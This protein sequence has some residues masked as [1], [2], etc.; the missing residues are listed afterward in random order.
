MKS[1]A[2]PENR[3]LISVAA[4]VVISRGERILATKL[5][6]IVPLFDEV[7]VVE[8]GSRDRSEAIADEY[9]AHYL[10]APPSESASGIDL[11]RRRIIQSDWLVELDG[12]ECPPESTILL[13]R[14]RLTQ[15]DFG[16]NVVV[17]SRGADF[18]SPGIKALRYGSSSSNVNPLATVNHCLT[19]DVIILSYCKTK[20]EYEMTCQCLRTLRASSDRIRFNVVMVETAAPHLLDGYAGAGKCF[21]DE[22]EVVFPQQKFNYNQFLQKGFERLQKSQARYLLIANNDVLFRPQFAEGLLESLGTYDSAS[23]WCPNYHEQYF[24]PRQRFHEGRRTSFELCGWGIAFRKEL[25][26]KVS[27]EELFPAEF[28]FW[29]QDNYY[30]WQLERLGARH[31]LVTDAK[32]EHLFNQSHSLIDADDKERFTAGAQD[33]FDRKTSS[34]QISEETLLTVAIASLPSRAGSSFPA[35]IEELARQAKGKP[36]EILSL[37]DNKQSTLGVKRNRLASLAKGRYISFVDDDDQVAP[38]YVESLV[39]AI[40]S[41]PGV[42]CVTFDAWVTVNGSSGKVCKYGVDYEDINCDDAYYRRPNHVCCFRT[43]IARCVPREDITWGEDSSWSK[44]AMPLVHR[45]LRLDRTLYYYRYDPSMSESPPPRPSGASQQ[46]RRRPRLRLTI[47]VLSIAARV[48]SFLPTLIER[49]AIQLRERPVELLVL[50]DNQLTSIG[51]KRNSLI[52]TAQGE[53]V[54]FVDDDDRVTDDYVDSLLQAI[55]DHAGVDCIV[56][57][58]WVTNDGAG[59]RTCRYGIEYD[60]ED[61]SDAYYRRPNHL[62][63][64]RTEIAKSVPFEAVSWHEDFCWAAALAPRL[65]TQAR[66]E[67]VLYYYDFCS[68]TSASASPEKHAALEGRRSQSVALGSSPGGRSEAE[69]PIYGF[70]HVAMMNHWR[71]VVEEQLLKLKASGLWDRTERIFVGLLGPQRDHFDFEDDK[72][73]VVYYSPDIEEAEFPTLMFLE[74]FCSSRDCFAYYLHTKGVF[75]VSP[76]TDDWRRL[77][78]HFAIYRHDECVNALVTHDVCGVNWHEQSIGPH[79]PGNFWWARSSYIRS[80]PSIHTFNADSIS[81][82]RDRHDCERWI[83]LNPAARVACLHQSGVN[84][85]DSPYPSAR[86][87]SVGEVSNVL[88]LDAPSAWRGLEQRFQNLIEGIGAIE[89]VVEIGVEYG[90][91]LFCFATALPNA[92]VIGIDPYQNVLSGH[93]AGDAGYGV[94]GSSD[95]EAWVRR[96]LPQF[97]RAILLR[98]E[99]R[100]I[101]RVFVGKIDVLHIDAI[102]SYQ[103]VRAD[104]EAW[105][106]HVRPGG[107]VLFHDT[108]SYPDDV[109]RFFR[110]LS[111][112]KAEIVEHHGLGAWY[113]PQRPVC[114]PDT[115]ST[116]AGQVEENAIA[117]AMS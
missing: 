54:A 45:E 12:A 14:E 69:L 51:E 99:S 28:E 30:G 36:V 67:R 95:S 74:D 101:A 18:E 110:E 116:R 22:C 13:L 3:P 77:M 105:E 19:V 68:A 29:F 88:A 24:D 9:G 111:G 56:F 106:P 55:N 91:S 25:L 96:F 115:Y 92:T 83:G 59:G 49:L 85:Y 70:I 37:M 17:V 44:A 39:E 114:R 60:N 108:R 93:Y 21:G 79:F 89:T 73:E 53:Y 4:C 15:A 58:A 43:E 81:N 42:D 23:P 107:C 80:L 109:G 32:V 41:E 31:V 8:V 57:D 94:M 46:E 50:L 75:R 86:Y 1:V 102:H 2:F 112:R 84:H 97:P 113:K 104:F 26:T 61:R 10:S 33:V 71:R 103:N 90:Y 63:A 78:E 35:L 20:R 65:R 48:R 38:N 7:I 52:A 27:F 66:I 6:A 5:A 100:E 98:A 76:H 47:A 72:L 34:A 62:C 87:S 64:I 40:Q 117:I 82:R 11:A 16:E